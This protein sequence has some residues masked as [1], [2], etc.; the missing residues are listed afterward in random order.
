MSLIAPPKTR[1]GGAKKGGGRRTENNRIYG[2]PLPVIVEKSHSWTGHILGLFGGSST[3]VLNPHC[4]GIF[5]PDTRSVWV[6]ETKDAMIL[7]RRGFFGKGDLS[8]SEP[9]WRARQITAGRAAAGKC[10]RRVFYGPK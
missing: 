1:Q 6:V 5:D 7:W 3:R 2:H 9:S 4:T 10:A 8:R